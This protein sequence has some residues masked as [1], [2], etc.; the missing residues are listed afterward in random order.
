MANLTDNIRLNTE[1][2][3]NGLINLIQEFKDLNIKVKDVAAASRAL[4]EQMKRDALEQTNSIKLVTLELISSGKIDEQIAKNKTANSNARA[5]ESKKES[6]EINKTANELVAYGKVDKQISENNAANHREVTAEINKETAAINKGTAER[7]Q[8]TAE[9]L[10][11]TA[12]VNQGTAEKKQDTAEIN[13]NTAAINQGTA[14]TKQ[15]TAELQKQRQIVQLATDQ[16]KLYNIELRNKALESNNA[17]EA[18]HKLNESIGSLTNIGS[19]FLAI[20]GI[21]TL[22]SFAKGI[23]DAHTKVESFDL[24]M[25]NLLGS[26]YGEKLTSDLKQF[27][28]ETPLNFEEVIKSASQLVGSFKAAGASSQEIGTQ[29][30]Q[31][32]ESLG[33][34]AA[35]LGGDDRLGRLIYAFSQVQ[36]TGRL[37]GTEVRQ[38]TETGFPL[39]SVIANWNEIRRT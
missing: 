29:V 33:N 31:I 4:T 26:K 38:I 3:L 2:D 36:A 6:A 17:R 34:S 39:L 28:V 35:A 16:K 20:F 30:P 23:I 27:T 5:A 12:A 14:A 13:K 18:T 22:G 25:K 10:K 37:M 24:S 15:D 11:N 8:D 9:I 19:A 21:D 1:V 32:L 7:K